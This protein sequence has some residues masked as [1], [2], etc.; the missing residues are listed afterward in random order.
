MKE[1]LQN[2]IAIIIIGLLFIINVFLSITIITICSRN[3]NL[4]NYKW[5]LNTANYIIICLLILILIV[6][7]VGIWKDFLSEG[8]VI[9]IVT[10]LCAM[11][12]TFYLYRALRESQR[13]NKISMFKAEY[14][15][16][17][18]EIKS[19]NK[20]KETPIFLADNMRLVTKIL[21]KRKSPTIKNGYAELYSFVEKLLEDPDYKTFI[22]NVDSII[23]AN[24]LITQYKDYI[25]IV[26]IIRTG[27]RVVLNYFKNIKSI[28]SNIRS[29]PLL[30]DL[31]IRLCEML[32]PTAQDCISF[33]SLISTHATEFESDS[34]INYSVIDAIEYRVS[35]GVFKARP[36]I[37]TKEFWSIGN[38]ISYLIKQIEQ[39]KK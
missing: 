32:K 20:K 36:K 21:N 22:V 33:C 14:D 12:T 3:K 25:E 8:G 38:D 30:P 15:D 19:L 9:A 16:F 1:I 37:F 2:P 6:S 28:F 4:N 24:T 10:A 5:Y 31:K 11:L 13:S 39:E 23:D 17:Y 18:D 29:S 26:S 35:N 7:I 34:P 27:E